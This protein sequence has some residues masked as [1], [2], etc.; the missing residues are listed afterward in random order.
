M[1]SG[2]LLSVGEEDENDDPLAMREDDSMGDLIGSDHDSIGDENDDEAEEDEEE[3]II[4]KKKPASIQVP[5][6]SRRTKESKVQP[7][8]KRGR[9]EPVLQTET[10]LKCSNKQ[11]TQKEK[12]RRKIDS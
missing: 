9:E 5:T 10:R 3:I 1:P 7:A 11:S 12:Q 8:R 2:N 6:S 4:R